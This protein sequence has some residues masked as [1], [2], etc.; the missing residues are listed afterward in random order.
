MPWAIVISKLKDQQ[1]K[2]IEMEQ[3]EWRIRTRAINF[4]KNAGM[5]EEAEAIELIEERV[6]RDYK[7]ILKRL[8]RANAI[9]NNRKRLLKKF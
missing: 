5:L 6:E 7:R 4:F 9:L 2:L 1:N 8:V 3:F